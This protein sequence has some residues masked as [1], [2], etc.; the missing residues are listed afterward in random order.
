MPRRNSLNRAEANVKWKK[1]NNIIRNIV[2]GMKKFRFPFF[3]AFVGKWNMEQYFFFVFDILVSK[4]ISFFRK[5][6]GVLGSFFSF[7]RVFA[8]L[9]G[10]RHDTCE[11]REEK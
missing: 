11:K 7:F 2:G 1:K 9:F 6:V 10:A 5:K 8:G 4:S 3:A